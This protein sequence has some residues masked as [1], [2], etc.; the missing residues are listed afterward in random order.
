MRPS[1]CLRQDLLTAE[2]RYTH[3]PRPAGGER[4]NATVQTYTRNDALRLL[5][6]INA[7]QSHGRVGA[8]VWPFVDRRSHVA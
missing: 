2:R 5:R 3:P 4:K 6:A 8:K 1:P 7:T